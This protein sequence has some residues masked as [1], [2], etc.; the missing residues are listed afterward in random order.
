MSPL[1]IQEPHM[2]F[3]SNLKKM[4]VRNAFMHVFLSTTLDLP[5][6]SRHKYHAA[7]S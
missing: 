2:L 1:N 4:L 3:L 5:H 6:F 7:L